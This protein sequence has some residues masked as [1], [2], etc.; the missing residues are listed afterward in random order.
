[1]ISE[2]ECDHRILYW[3]LKTPYFANYLCDECM[4]KLKQGIS[5]PKIKHPVSENKNILTNKLINEIKEELL[6]MRQRLLEIN[7]RLN[8]VLK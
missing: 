2:D 5:I 6:V 7:N 4:G 8:E 1:M 3:A